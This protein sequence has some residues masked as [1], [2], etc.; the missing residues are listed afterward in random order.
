[1][2]FRYITVSIIISFLVPWLIDASSCSTSLTPK[3]SIKPS[4]AS[5]YQFALVATG[6]TRPRSIQFDS[7]GNLLVVQRG[8][9]IANLILQDEG[10]VCLS[11]KA[12]RDVI[13]NGDVSPLYHVYVFAF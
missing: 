7:L 10:G 11:V 1:M 12:N 5:G 4:I 6:L 2:S 13:K 9:G 3:N 8:R